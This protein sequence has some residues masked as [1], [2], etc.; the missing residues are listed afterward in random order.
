MNV[1]LRGTRIIGEILPPETTVY[2]ATLGYLPSHTL[3]VVSS[4]VPEYQEG[5]EILVNNMTP[6]NDFRSQMQAG[7]LVLTDAKSVL[8]RVSGKDIIP[9]NGRVL[10]T[11]EGPT[12]PKVSKFSTGPIR[13]SH[14]F[15][16]K[17]GRLFV[18]MNTAGWVI[19]YFGLFYRIFDQEDLLLEIEQ[20]AE[21]A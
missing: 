9:C 18:A 13:T 20:E 5:T 19:Q 8:A 21:N 1:K 3:R 4:A 16:T 7:M 2:V 10:A 17:D 11:D 6:L 12:D 14:F 15:K